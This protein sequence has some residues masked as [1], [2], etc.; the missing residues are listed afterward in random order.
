MKF[1]SNDFYSKLLK[2][3]S[4]KQDKVAFILEHF[5]E[6]RNSDNLL[7]VM[8]WKLVDGAKYVDDIQFATNP[9]V[10]R[11]ARQKIQNE[12]KRFLPTDPEIVKRRRIEA[13]IVRQE[14]HSV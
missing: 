13:E 14:I 2:D 8:Y 7:C 6:T 5:P 12:H 9:E 1:I 11:R 10:I 3:L 4:H